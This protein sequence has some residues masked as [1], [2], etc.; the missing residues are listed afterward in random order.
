MDGLKR[1]ENK[2]LDEN[3]DKVEDIEKKEIMDDEASGKENEKVEIVEE[4]K[5]QEVDD[6]ECTCSE[7]HGLL[8]WLLVVVG[9]AFIIYMSIN[10]G[11]KIS[12][13]IEGNVVDE[14]NTKEEEP[15]K[16]EQKQVVNNYDYT[17]F[18]RQKLYASDTNEW[19]NKATDYYL[20][21]INKDGIDELFVV[22][23]DDGNGFFYTAIYT[24]LD[25]QVVLVD[26]IYTYGR[27]YGNNVDGGIVYS[28]FRTTAVQN[29]YVLYKL[30]GATLV[31]DENTSFETGDERIVVI[32]PTKLP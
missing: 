15:E 7:K 17:N 5:N 27:V 3:I 31:V 32:E 12:A 24:Y 11:K 6:K 22:S 1:D 10:I 21:D 26:N 23:Y 2:E 8:Y 19:I 9:V 30:E 16:K 4:E 18:L 20:Y 28:L 13:A 25:E 14:Q 29:Y